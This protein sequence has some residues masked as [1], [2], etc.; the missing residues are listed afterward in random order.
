[1]PL[2]T[3]QHLRTLLAMALQSALNGPAFDKSS[4]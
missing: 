3:P 4:L 1:L 2:S